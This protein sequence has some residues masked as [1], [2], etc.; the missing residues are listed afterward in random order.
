[1]IKQRTIADAVTVAG[2]GVHSGEQATVRIKPGPAASGIRF[3][4]TDLPGAP[5][6]E[7]SPRAIHSTAQATVLGG[8]GF[9]VATTEHC[10]AALAGLEIDNALVEV[11]GG[12]LPIGD[13]SARIYIDALDRAGVREQEADR[14]YMVITERVVYGDEE[15]FAAMEPFD[16]LRIA[17]FI[18]F[19]HPCIGE[20]SLE[21]DVN[22][23]VFR[24]EIGPAR[25]FGFLKDRE[26]A[27]AAGIGRGAAL[28]NTLALDDTGLVNAGGLRF[29]DEFVRH[30]M[31]DALGD[32]AV[33]GKPA[34]GR[35]V[36]RR[37][38][39]EV[40][41]GLVKKLA[42]TEGCYRLERF[43]SPPATG[44]PPA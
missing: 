21:L 1:M 31:L 18:A 16:G 35:L 6:V 44:Q 11:D 19:D 42:E 5:G 43:P 2:V 30:K 25:T 27:L 17:C 3:V 14:E 29:P 26:R 4:R 22:P 13:G 7:T 33:L 28:E 36:A 12:E 32:L 41:Q 39:H 15:T 40:M 34:R 37:S 8:D 38:G 20:Q 23:G 10:L 9:T 24:R